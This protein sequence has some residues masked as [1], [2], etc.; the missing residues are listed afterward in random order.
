MRIRW[1]MLLDSVGHL[2]KYLDWVE[3]EVL[4]LVKFAYVESGTLKSNY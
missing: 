3:S 4:S 2:V 1:N